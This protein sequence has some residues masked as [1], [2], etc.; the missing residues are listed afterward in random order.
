MFLGVMMCGLFPS[1]RVRSC[2]DEPCSCVCCTVVFMCGMWMCS[3]YLVSIIY[4]FHCVACWR[5]DTCGY[6]INLFLSHL[7][8]SLLIPSYPFSSLFSSLLIPSH[9]N[10]LH[11]RHDDVG[12]VV[13]GWVV[14][15]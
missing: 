12:R 8:S 7:F 14:V 4:C 6:T 9:A 15:Q 5:V 10:L 1:S 13:C 3:V 11:W 2:V